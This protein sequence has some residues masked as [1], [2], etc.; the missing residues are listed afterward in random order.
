MVSGIPLRVRAAPWAQGTAALGSHGQVADRSNTTPAL[1]VHATVDRILRNWT[2][3]VGF[4]PAVLLS[5]EKSFG[6]DELIEL[7]DDAA[8]QVAGTMLPWDD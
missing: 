7:V 6:P 4:A 2:K 3:M 1:R 8:R 5:H